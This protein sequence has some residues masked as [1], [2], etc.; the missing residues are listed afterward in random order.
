MVAFQSVRPCA[1]TVSR[2]MTVSSALLLAETSEKR[3]GAS[4]LPLPGRSPLE[5][6]CEVAHPMARY[7]RSRQTLFRLGH[8]LR[9]LCHRRAFLSERFYRRGAFHSGPN[10]ARSIRDHPILNNTIPAIHRP[11]LLFFCFCS[12]SEGEWRDAGMV[13]FSGATIN[14]GRAWIA[15]VETSV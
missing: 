11:L 4:R 5:A 1:S 10:S 6:S 13:G 8:W 7:R 3:R 14:G 12:D 15:G 9:H 2:S